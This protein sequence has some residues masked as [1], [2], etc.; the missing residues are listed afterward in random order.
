MSIIQLLIQVRS[1][2]YIEN[3]DAARLAAIAPFNLE[4]TD[5]MAWNTK[6]F[7]NKKLIVAATQSLDDIQDLQDVL[8][9]PELSFRWIILAATNGWILNVHGDLVPNHLI[10]YKKGVVRD[11]LIN[12]P[13]SYEIGRFQGICPCDGED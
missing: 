7:S 12:N 2:D 1:R 11:Y 5:L 3:L 8:D 13:D 4:F 9:A 6:E 10:Y